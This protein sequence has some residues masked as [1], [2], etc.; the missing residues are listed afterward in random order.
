MT[1]R[2]IDPDVDLHVPAQRAEVSGGVLAVIAVGGA[3]GALAR[4]GVQTVMPAGPADFPWA[5]FWVNVPGCLLI[6][7]L[8]VVITEVR[9]AHRLVRPFLGVGV[10]G[11]YTTF[12]TYTDGVRQ[13]VEAGAPVTG[14]VYLVG[15][16]LAALAAVVVG[17]W[18]TRRI[19][20]V[21]RAWAK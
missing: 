21:T 2:P 14:L 16:P 1:D 17:M 4:Y 13:A 11:G 9:R 6:G 18:L 3:L 20:G 15:T 8:M 19:A 12:S 7:V 5:T 10:L